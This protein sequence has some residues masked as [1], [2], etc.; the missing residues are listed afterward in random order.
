M[1]MERIKEQYQELF[2]EPEANTRWKASV[3]GISVE[4]WM[5]LVVEWHSLEKM[6]RAGLLD[7]FAWHKRIMGIHDVIVAERLSKEGRLN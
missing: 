7:S 1:E 3:Y 2:N 4:A 5:F 6:V